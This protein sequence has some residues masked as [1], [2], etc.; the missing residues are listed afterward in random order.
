MYLRSSVPQSC[1]EVTIVMPHIQIRRL[2]PC[3]GVHSGVD[4]AGIEL[5]GLV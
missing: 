2:K 1:K 5:L 4:R 3:P